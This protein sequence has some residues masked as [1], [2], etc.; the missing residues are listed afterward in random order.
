VGL[1]SK[2][3][4]AP[5]LRPICGE[6]FDRKETAIGLLSHWESHVQIIGPGQGDAT[7][8]FTWRCSCGP[9]NMKWPHTGGAGAGLG[10]HMSERHGLRMI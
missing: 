7:G 6:G 8:Q 10:L 9:A 3:P 5:W 2:T 1:F 4:P